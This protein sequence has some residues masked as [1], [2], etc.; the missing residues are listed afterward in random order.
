MVK[1]N[2]AQKNRM[3]SPMWGSLVVLFATVGSIISCIP[4]PRL[5]ATPSPQ[6]LIT[7]TCDWWFEPYTTKELPDLSREWQTRLNEAGLDIINARVEGVG[8]T[9]VI[10]CDGEVS[11]EWL[12]SSTWFEAEVLVDSI[13]DYEMLGSTLGR[14]LTETESMVID[15]SVPVDFIHLM[16]KSRQSDNE[17]VHLDFNYETGMKLLDQGLRGKE[18]FRRI[19]EIP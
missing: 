10:S 13:N 4:S 17:E 18:L 7:P 9:G 19:Q 14:V 1:I 8:E 16:M 2:Q 6:S 12:W 15:K 11:E 5:L 3:G